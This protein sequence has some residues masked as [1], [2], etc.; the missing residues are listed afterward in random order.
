L[1]IADYSFLGNYSG[2]LGFNEDA[3]EKPYMKPTLMLAGRQDSIV[4]Y[5]GLYHIIEMYPRASFILLDKAGHDLQIEQDV[6]F[7]EAV[8]EWLNRVTAEI[9]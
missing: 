4:G 8:K 9:G 7:T 2:Q 1:K 6:L 5:R 3:L